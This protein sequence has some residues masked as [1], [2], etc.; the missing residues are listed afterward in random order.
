MLMGPR[1][2]DSRERATPDIG[3]LLGSVMYISAQIYDVTNAAFINQQ[4]LNI[5]S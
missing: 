1:L 4:M 2:C 3:V 5:I